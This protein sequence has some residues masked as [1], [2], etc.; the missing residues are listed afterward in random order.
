[1]ISAEIAKS[2]AF[3]FRSGGR[4]NAR[5][6]HLGELDTSDP[7]ASAC[8]Q[9]EH[10]I[11]GFNLANLE[12]HAN[13]GAIGNRHRRSDGEIEI[14]RKTNEIVGG[15]PHIFSHSTGNFFAHHPLMGDR[16]QRDAIADM[17]AGHF[18]AERC[19]RTGDIAARN[20]WHRYRKARHA[21]PDEDVEMVEAAAT[22]F[23]KDLALAGNRVRPIAID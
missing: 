14:G 19:D 5:A 8:S 4:D 6:D 15:N 3:G 2:L 10:K 11:G 7:H 21:S 13:R 17:P 20:E 9:Y 23:D 16:M 18:R 1:M 22:N 12:Q